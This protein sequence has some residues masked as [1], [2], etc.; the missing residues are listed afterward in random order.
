MNFLGLK[1]FQADPEIWTR[2]PTKTDGTDYWE[3][4]ILYVD[5]CLVVSNHGKKILR[6]DIVKYFKLKYNSIGPPN[7]YLSGKMRRVKLENG[8]KAWAFSSSHYV[9]E[10]VNNVE[11]YLERKEKKLNAKAGAPISNRYRPEKEATD[12]LRPVDAAY[13]Q[14]LIGILRLMVELG[15][16]NICVEI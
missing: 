16:V 9:V 13:Y 4:V 14:S 11:A 10:A 7:V 5:E 6:E 15:R 8:S 2:E 3:Y 12:E 1:S